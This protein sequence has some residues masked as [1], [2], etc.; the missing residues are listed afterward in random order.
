MN[1][2]FIPSILVGGPVGSAGYEAAGIALPIT[3]LTFSRSFESQADYL[4]AEYMYKAGYDP[5]AFITFFEKVEALKK[6]KPGTV[7]KAFATHPQTPDRVEKTQEE[8]KTV[9]P[10]KMEYKLDTSEF[11]DVKARLA[12]LENRHVTKSTRRTPADFATRFTR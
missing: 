5:Q 2:A 7:A 3:F 6:H 8:I 9:L 4:G 11:E 10:T 1:L 12:K